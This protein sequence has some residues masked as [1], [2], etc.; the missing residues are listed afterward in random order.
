M[1]STPFFDAVP[2]ITTGPRTAA[3]ATSRAPT[4]SSDR[5]P[6]LGSGDLVHDLGALAMIAVLGAGLLAAAVGGIVTVVH[7]VLPALSGILG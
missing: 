5:R 6:A 3:T 7:V 4:T 2:D 1:T